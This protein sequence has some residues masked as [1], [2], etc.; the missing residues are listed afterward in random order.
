M[1]CLEQVRAASNSGG[2]IKSGKKKLYNCESTPKHLSNSKMGLSYDRTKSFPSRCKT[3]SDSSRSVPLVSHKLSFPWLLIVIC[4]SLQFATM[5]VESL[6]L[7]LNDIQSYLNSLD[8]SHSDSKT[9]P[10]SLMWGIG[11]TTAF[12][13]RMFTYAIPSDAFKGTIQSFKVTEAGKEEW[14][15]WLYF[16]QE[17]HTFHGVPTLANIGQYY[18]EVIAVAANGDVAKDVFSIH[19]VKETKPISA[20]KSL[21]SSISSSAPFVRCSPGEAETAFTLAVDAD[22]S[23]MSPRSIVALL[24]DLEQYLHLASEMFKVSPAGNKPL[25]DTTALVSGPGNTK[26]PKYPGILVTWLVGCGKVEPAHMPVLQKIETTSF[27]GSLSDAIKHSII[28]WQV[29][30]NK[31]HQEKRVRRAIMATPT[32]SFIPTSLTRRHD[33]DAMTHQVLTME[34]PIVPSTRTHQKS[35]TRHP[36]STATYLH[37]SIYVPTDGD[38]SKTKT[39][40]DASYTI[41]TGRIQ[42]TRVNPGVNPTRPTPPMTKL[43]QCM[44]NRD[45]RPMVDKRIPPVEVVAGEIM[46]FKVPSDTFVDCEDGKTEDLRLDFFLENYKK[47]PPESWLKAENKKQMVVGL[48][49]PSD[50]GLYNMSVVAVDSAGLKEVLDFHFNVVN[51]PNVPKTKITHKINMIFDIDY[52]VFMSEIGNR[53]NLMKKIARLY[54]DKNPS[55]ISVLDISQG[56]VVFSWTNNT[57]VSEKCPKEETEQLLMKLVDEDKQVTDMAK[58]ALKPFKLLSAQI[59]PMGPCSSDYTPVLVGSTPIVPVSDKPVHTQKEEPS[60]DD[61]LISTVVPAIIIVSILL[62]ALLVACILYR[63]KR[64]GKMSLSEQEAYAGKGAPVIFADELD[65]KPTDCSRPLI[66]DEEKPPHPPPE[67]QASSSDSAQST[68]HQD[69]RGENEINMPD[70]TSPLYEPPPPVTASRVNKQP[71]PHVQPPYRTPP[72]YVPP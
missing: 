3:L 19:V 26:T 41:A 6:E 24:K 48:P 65:E 4:I 7:R 37:P 57:L 43:P 1:S 16:N 55:K 11:D 53:L 67:Y 59:T 56:S 54:G 44:D 60:D 45:D 49:L 15:N 18:I 21:K 61:I 62:F 71:R 12:V 34:S 40:P 23:L 50:V 5:Q 31:I 66:L 58:K 22:M 69:R 10:V 47:I 13:G 52:D 30:N 51:N 39:L 25:F 72:P 36:E 38:M 32:M 28:G 14:P 35:K 63:K 33:S 8:G 29:T 20:A 64:K 2:Q 70:I 46:K 42:P 68:P 9:Q 27:N 17:T